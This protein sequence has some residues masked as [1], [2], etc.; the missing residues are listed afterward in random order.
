MSQKTVL[1]LGGY[2]NT[3]LALAHLLLQETNVRLILAGRNRKKA[4]NSAYH[5][6]IPFEPNEKRVTGIVADASNVESLKQAFQ[7]VD[8]V[9]VASS[10]ANYA[11]EVITAALAI[12]VDYLDVQ[13]SREKL[14][15][16]RAW[17]DDIEQAGRCFITEA[18]FHPGMPAALVRY[19]ATFFDCMNQ[20][21][22]S[23]VVNLGGTLPKSM[24]TLYEFV[25]EFKNYDSYIFKEGGWREAS[26]TTMRDMYRTDFG[27]EFGKR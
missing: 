4:E 6:N 12:G 20:A 21:V 15:T 10:T 24:D 18:G 5:L 11:K 25:E 16:L 8:F 2:G 22:A 14:E 26:S 27:P 19:A 7:G 17:K 3:G 1:I 13:Y 23:S 9:V